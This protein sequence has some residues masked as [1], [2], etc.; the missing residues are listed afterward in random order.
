M[1][2][3]EFLAAMSSDKHHT[4]PT[5]T[6]PTVPIDAHMAA[7]TSTAA[8]M[9]SSTKA[10]VSPTKYQASDDDEYEDIEVGKC[11]LPRKPPRRKVVSRY[12]SHDEAF[13]MDDIIGAS[14][15]EQ[16]PQPLPSSK[17]ENVMS[18]DNEMTPPPPPSPLQSELLS[19][20]SKIPLNSVDGMHVENFELSRIM[21]HIDVSF[22]FF[23]YL[24][25]NVR[26]FSLCV[27]V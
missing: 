24:S 11:H 10:N 3:S 18:D 13:V 25:L 22:F 6:N 12:V 19:S 8:R 1:I 17:E 26:K 4:M 15:Q 16:Q 27:F 2:E 9:A 14:Q 7:T 20:S 21:G 5:Q 23:F